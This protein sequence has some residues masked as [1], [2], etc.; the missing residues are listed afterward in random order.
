MPKKTLQT[1]IQ[2]RNKSIGDLKKQ[3]AGCAYDDGF[4]CRAF[5]HRPKECH[6]YTSN[7]EAQKREEEI[8]GYHQ[9]YGGK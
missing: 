8:K 7:K 1:P 9:K 3:C 5:I 6:N 4:R 2:I